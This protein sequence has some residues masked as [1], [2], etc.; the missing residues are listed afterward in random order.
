MSGGMLVDMLT[1]AVVNQKGGVGKTASV[2]GL[3]DALSV[4]DRRVLVVDMDPQAN[5]TTGLGATVG[6]FNT[7]DVL[8][9][10][11]DG[12]IVDAI[13]DAG[14]H[15]SPLIKCVPASLSVAEREQDTTMGREFRLKKAMTGLDG[16]DVVLIDC[17]PSV[18]PLVTNALVAADRALIVTQAAAAAL[19]G[20]DKVMGTITAARE[21]YNPNLSI[22]G[23]IVNLLPT[24]QRESRARLED[25]VA[26]CG[27]LVWDP[28]VPARV[29]VSEAYGASAPVRL[30]ANRGLDAVAAYDL[31]AARLV[32]L[33]EDSWH[34]Q[35]AAQA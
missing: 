28:Y 9:S 13:V 23:I 2:L 20:V 35:P 7:N 6:Q 18:G 31:L 5:A 10:G 3:A 11:L 32:A 19:E 4:I 34:N 26:S 24:G 25:L 8:V 14:E 29:I 1:V 15:W 16:F 12:V 21:F 30:F 33:K 27:D 22:A 17:P